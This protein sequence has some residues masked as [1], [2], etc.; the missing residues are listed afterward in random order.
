MATFLATELYTAEYHPVEHWA[1]IEVKGD[2][3]KVSF[4][5]VVPNTIRV[6]VEQL[7]VSIN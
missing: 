5:S 6:Q 7:R 1:D 2:V 4:L 3:A